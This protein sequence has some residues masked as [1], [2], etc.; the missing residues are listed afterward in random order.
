MGCPPLLLFLRE[1]V[2]ASK[3]EKGLR[4]KKDDAN[5]PSRMGPMTRHV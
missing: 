5:T 3:E 2:M 4:G 1:K